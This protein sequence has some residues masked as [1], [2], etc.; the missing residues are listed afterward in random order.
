MM[1]QGRTRTPKS[2][3]D[4]RQQ[5]VFMGHR[6]KYD[7]PLSGVAARSCVVPEQAAGKSDFNGTTYY[8]FSQQCKE[9]FD[10]SPESY[11]KRK[12]S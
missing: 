4:V 8:F 7:R 3:A 1:P 9:N 10:R 5:D 2:V 12:T 11:G 6:R